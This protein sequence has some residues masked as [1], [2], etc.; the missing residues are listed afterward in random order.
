MVADV[1]LV[2]VRRDDQVNGR[3]SLRVQGMGKGQEGI[4]RKWTLFIVSRWD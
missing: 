3:W 4:F 1:D 2:V